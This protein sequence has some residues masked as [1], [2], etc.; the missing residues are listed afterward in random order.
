MNKMSVAA[1]ERSVRPVI[2]RGGYRRPSFPRN[3]AKTDAEYA[4]KTLQRIPQVG[5]L[6]LPK[7]YFII[8]FIVI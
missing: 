5:K 2:S 3:P 7:H 6:Y 1:A 4:T 8:P